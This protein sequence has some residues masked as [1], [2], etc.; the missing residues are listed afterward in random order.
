M[1][2]TKTFVVLIIGLVCVQGTSVRV[3]EVSEQTNKQL[4]NILTMPTSKQTDKSKPN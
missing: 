2:L 4:Q 1:I 3:P